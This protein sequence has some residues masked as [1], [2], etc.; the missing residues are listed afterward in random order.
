MIVLQNAGKSSGVLDVMILS[1]FIT[2]ISSQNAPAFTKSSFIAK[3]LVSFLSLIM[4]ADADL[5][6]F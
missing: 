4:S 2:S 5:F 3:K 1:S 6:I